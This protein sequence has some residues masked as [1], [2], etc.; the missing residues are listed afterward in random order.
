[1]ADEGDPNDSLVV[2]ASFSDLE[3]LPEGQ[4][5]VLGIGVANASLGHGHMVKAELL[6][7]DVVFDDEHVAP[8][9]PSRNTFLRCLLLTRVV[10]PCISIKRVFRGSS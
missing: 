9:L 8:S 10:C 2:E 7:R 6:Y 3:R 5:L 4:H 1:M